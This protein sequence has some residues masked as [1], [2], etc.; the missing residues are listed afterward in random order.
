MEN[1]ILSGSVKYSVRIFWVIK[2][3][4][5]PRISATDFTGKI[6]LCLKSQCLELFLGIQGF[7]GGGIQAGVQ[8]GV[9][10]RAMP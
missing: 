4:Q 1:G 2:L 9:K 7:R 8:R 6:Q 5:F 10:S 3:K